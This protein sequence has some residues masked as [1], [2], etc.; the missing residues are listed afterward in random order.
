MGRS[1]R[2][3]WG[4]TEDIFLVKARQGFLLRKFN[5]IQFNSLP[6]EKKNE[7]PRNQE[8]VE[9]ARKGKKEMIP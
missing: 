7:K 4:R 6:Q 9:G 1:P 5:L 8:K 2:E 3:S